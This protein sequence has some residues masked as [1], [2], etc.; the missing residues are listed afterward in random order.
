MRTT[1][2]ITGQLHGNTLLLNGLKSY[3]FNGQVKKESFNNYTVEYPTK[4]LAIKSL[5]YCI[6][7]VNA[8]R[9]QDERKYGHLKSLSI[10]FDASPASII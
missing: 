1:I 9:E 3:L 4:K 2:S 8:N 5:Q 6:R 7:S 10:A